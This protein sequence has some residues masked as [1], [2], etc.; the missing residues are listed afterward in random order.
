MKQEARK[1]S[2]AAAGAMFLHLS[3]VI[4]AG[5]LRNFLNLSTTPLMIYDILASIFSLTLAYLSF[6]VFSKRFGCPDIPPRRETALSKIDKL[7]IVFAVSAITFIFGR[8]YA[9][10]FPSSTT[11]SFPEKPTAIQYILL[12]IS[13]VIVPSLFEELVFRKSLARQF[14][15]IGITSA[16]II[17]ALIFGLTHFSLEAFPYAFICGILIGAAYLITGSFWVAFGIHFFTNAYS[18]FFSVAEV[19][20]PKKAFAA[21]NTSMA[22]ALFSIFLICSV[23]LF[24]RLR[25]KTFPEEPDHALASDFLTWAISAYLLCALGAHV[26]LR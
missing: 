16:T 26:L 20:L 7:S 22:V 6:S 10:L 3:A 18:Y 5:F 14:R 17:S 21:S 19:F 24:F 1:I 11:V 4:S 2:C 9:I 8:I 15:V 23:Y 25:G 12:F 13:S